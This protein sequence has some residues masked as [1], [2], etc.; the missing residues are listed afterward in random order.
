VRY[1]SCQ[2]VFSL[3]LLIA[4]PLLGSHGQA[5]AGY[6]TGGMGTSVGAGSAPED[7]L[8]GDTFSGEAGLGL[9]CSEECAD[10][11]QSNENHDDSAVLPF[12]PFLVLDS[13]PAPSPGGG[14]AGAGPGSGSGPSVQQLGV[15]SSPEVPRSTLVAQLFIE[16]AVCPPP[17]H[18]SGLFRPPRLLRAPIAFC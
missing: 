9:G 6:V 1:F 5:Q 14:G 11:D 17:P 10:P 7:R 3:A 15:L 4:W 12:C 18:I 13:P 8:L 2:F 16:N